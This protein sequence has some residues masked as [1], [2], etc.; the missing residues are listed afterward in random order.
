MM[1]LLDIL[2]H[3]CSKYN[4]DYIYTTT[5]TISLNS[6]NTSL[7]MVDEVFHDD[8]HSDSLTLCLTSNN[9]FNQSQAPE[10]HDGGLKW[11]KLELIKQ[12]SMLEYC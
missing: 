7:A 3:T 6:N 12:V 8:T 10:G 5:N 2:Q 1:P 4:Y 11:V 9:T